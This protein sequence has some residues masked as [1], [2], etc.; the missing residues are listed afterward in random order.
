MSDRLMP[1][2]F[3]LSLPVLRH[4]RDKNGTVPT[5]E[6]IFHKTGHSLL[7]DTQRTKDG[8]T[9]IFPSGFIITA[10]N[11]RG[12]AFEAP[13]KSVASTRFNALVTLYTWMTRHPH[14][15]LDG[16]DVGPYDPG[17]IK[18]VSV[19]ANKTRTSLLFDKTATEDGPLHPDYVNVPQLPLMPVS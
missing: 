6:M 10:T 1:N 11:A 17:K 18:I 15:F 16:I 2:E 5:L 9:V 13:L 8:D 4:F 7:F 19:N 12:E 14:R 3:V